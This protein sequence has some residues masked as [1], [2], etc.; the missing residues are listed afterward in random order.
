MAQLESG[1]AAR[2]FARLPERW[3][4]VLWHTEVEQECPADV[5]P[6][7]GLTAERGGRAG[8]PGP[9]GAAAGVPAGARRRGLLASGHGRAPGHGRSARRLDPRRPVQPAPGPGRR[10]PRELPAVPGAGRRAGGRQRRAARRS[11]RPRPDLRGCLGRPARPTPPGPGAA[12]RLILAGR[13]PAAWI[14]GTAGYV[15]VVPS[16]PSNAQA[17]RVYLLAA[18]LWLA[19]AALAVVRL[20]GVIAEP[21]R[22]MSPRRQRRHGRALRGG[23]R[24]LVRAVPTQPRRLRLAGGQQRGERVES[25]GDEPVVGPLAALLAVQQARVDEHL[26]VVRDGGLGQRRPGR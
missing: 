9:G 26:H 11:G 25:V 2:A 5:A 19:A 4:T 14:G 7:L 8:V 16:T 15:R 24:H 12:S 3:Q 22:E 6:V 20:A 23:G 1:L 21:D 10:P 18:V 13:R 17:R